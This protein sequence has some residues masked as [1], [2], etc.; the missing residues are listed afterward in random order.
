[1]PEFRRKPVGVLAVL[2]ETTYCIAASYEAKVFG[3]KT[4]TVLRDARKLCPDMIFVEARP[5]A[6]V[7]FHHNTLGFVINATYGVVAG[8]PVE[9][10]KNP[11]MD[12][13]TK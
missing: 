7:T 12:N 2:V 5:A 13:G 10:V 8:K 1:M 6:N 4:E 11:I 9:V 3:I